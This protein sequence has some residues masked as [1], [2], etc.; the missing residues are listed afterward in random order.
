MRS[1]KNSS[2][3]SMRRS[4][5]RMTTQQ[6]MPLVTNGTITAK[7]QCCGCRRSYPLTNRISCLISGTAISAKSLLVIRHRR[8]TCCVVILRQDWRIDRVE[9]FLLD[10]IRNLH[11]HATQRRGQGARL[12]VNQVLKYGERVG[13]GCMYNP[14][15]GAYPATS[16]AIAPGPIE[17][18][19]SGADNPVGSGV[20]LTRGGHAGLARLP[21][22]PRGRQ[23]P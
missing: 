8:T 11:F 21:L 19:V 12:P 2:P 20:S 9:L 22:R 10:L 1:S 7:P 5:R 6:V 23:F 15:A 13:F 16:P 17:W 3:R 18:W 14:S 4:W